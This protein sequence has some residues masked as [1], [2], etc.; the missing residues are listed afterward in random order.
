[1]KYRR[2]RIQTF[3]FSLYTGLQRDVEAVLQPEPQSDDERASLYANVD[4][5]ETRLMQ[6]ILE[7]VSLSRNWV[8]VIIMWCLHVTVIGLPSPRGANVHFFLSLSLSIFSLC[9]SH[10][11]RYKSF[12]TE[13]SVDHGL[14][15]FLSRIID[16]TLTFTCLPLRSSTETDSKSSNLTVMPRT[17]R[18]LLFPSSH[19]PDS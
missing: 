5:L 14:F 15:C 3:M 11:Q 6:S 1:M 17:A 2:F 7:F 19:S 12:K 9:L 18:R 13:F 10:H 4:A 8:R 16:R